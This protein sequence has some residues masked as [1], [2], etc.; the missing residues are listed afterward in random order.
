LAQSV[1]HGAFR[2]KVDGSPDS[3]R[4]PFNSSK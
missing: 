2:D 4:D 1:E 3:Y